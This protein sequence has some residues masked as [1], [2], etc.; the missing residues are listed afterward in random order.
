TWHQL[1]IRGNGNR[2]QPRGV[3]GWLKELGIFGQRSFQKRVPEAAFRLGN[4][5]IA[6]LLQHLWATGGTIW[7]RA[8][9][10]GSHRVYY[11]TNSAGLAGDVA[12]LL[13]RLGIVTRTYVVAQRGYRPAHHVAVSGAAAQRRFLETVGA[14]GPRQP[15]SDRLLAALA[16]HHSE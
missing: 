16:G 12:S 13:L 4:R 7:S 15:Q 2:W 6:L 11:S 5:Q 10:R 8:N 9:G 14:F 1:L 3:G